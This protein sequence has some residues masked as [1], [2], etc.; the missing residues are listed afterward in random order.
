MRRDV[1]WAKW[2]VINVFHDRNHHFLRFNRQKRKLD[3]WI[4]SAWTEWEVIHH[5]QRTKYLFLVHHVGGDGD[6]DRYLAM[7]SNRRR[8]DV[9]R[10]ILKRKRLHRLRNKLRVLCLLWSHKRTVTA[11]RQRVSRILDPTGS[12]KQ[13]S[14]R[15]RCLECMCWF[16]WR[17]YWN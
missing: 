13:Q 17:P 7:D 1:K 15:G 14:T 8:N 11:I 16:C 9:S 12:F 6:N 4:R 5:S 2:I 3:M 10:S